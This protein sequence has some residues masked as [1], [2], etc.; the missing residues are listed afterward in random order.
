[1]DNAKTIAALTELID[2]VLTSG[3]CPALKGAVVYDTRIARNGDLLV[4][5]LNPSTGDKDTSLT[6]TTFRIQITTVL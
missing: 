6:T 1:M 4:E 5:F 3:E 2:Q